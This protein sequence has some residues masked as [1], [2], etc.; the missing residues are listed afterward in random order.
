MHRYGALWSFRGAFVVRGWT[1]KSGRMGSEGA[2]GLVE[3]GMGPFASRGEGYEA[4]CAGGEES[5]AGGLGY[6]GG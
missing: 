1:V 2:G 6:A 3:E 4:E 5:Q